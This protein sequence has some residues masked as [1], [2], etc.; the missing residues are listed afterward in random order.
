MTATIPVSAT[1]HVLDDAAAVQFPN[2]TSYSKT[3][4]LLALGDVR[5]AMLDRGK[6]YEPSDDDYPVQ[7]GSERHF[8]LDADRV[9]WIRRGEDRDVVVH[10]NEVKGGFQNSTVPGVATGAGVPPAPE[11]VAPGDLLLFEVQPD[12]SLALILANELDALPEGGLVGQTLVRTADGYGWMDF[13]ADVDEVPDGGTPGFYLMKTAEGVAWREIVL[14]EGDYEQPATI[15]GTEIVDPSAPSSDYAQADILRYTEIKRSGSENILELRF[16]ADGHST[17]DIVVHVAPD[18]TLGESL[19][20]FQEQVRTRAGSAW[21]AFEAGIRNGRIYISMGV[22]SSES[23]TVVSNPYDRFGLTPDVT[24]QPVTVAPSLKSVQDALARKVEFSH[25]GKPRGIATLGTDGKVPAR[26]LPAPTPP[27]DDTEV[28]ANIAALDGRVT[29]LEEAGPSG[30]ETRLT[31]AEEEL[32][33]APSSPMSVTSSVPYEPTTEEL[34]PALIATIAGAPAGVSA[35][36]PAN[37]SLEVVLQRL[38]DAFQSNGFTEWEAVVTVDGNISI[39]ADFETSEIEFDSYDDSWALLGFVEPYDIQDRVFGTGLGRVTSRL[40]DVEDRFSPAEYMIDA[41]DETVFGVHP[42]PE[43][44]LSDAAGLAGS[45]MLIDAFGWNEGDTFS[46]AFPSAEGELS[47]LVGANSSVDDLRNYIFD[48][49]QRNGDIIEKGTGQPIFFEFYIDN[50]GHLVVFTNTSFESVGSVTIPGFPESHSAPHPTNGL[51]DRFEGATLP[52]KESRLRLDAADFI[53]LELTPNDYVSFS[54][55]LD[56]S[57]QAVSITEQ[58][59][60]SALGKTSIDTLGELADVLN[61]LVYPIAEIS[62][63]YDGPDAAYME[64]MRPFGTEGPNVFPIHLDN[65]DVSAANDLGLGY[66]MVL[67]EGRDYHDV[68]DRFD[69][70]EKAIGAIEEQLEGTI[71]PGTPGTSAVLEGGLF[72]VA[73][74]TLG[75]VVFDISFDFGARATITLNQ[76]DPAFADPAAAIIDEVVAAIATQ[77]ANAGLTG[78]VGTDAS[79]TKIAF[80]SLT[81]GV[82]S[83]VEITNLIDPSGDTGLANGVTYGQDGTPEMSLKNRL[84]KLEYEIAT[85]LAAQ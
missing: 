8:H 1:S 13:P 73:D 82:N 77:L 80:T 2:T 30:L 55:H 45:S 49:V 79:G 27:Y 74:I 66:Y 64:F 20:G 51:W 53:P 48:T 62:T 46:L 7:A 71:T 28:V 40:N 37:S 26:Q 38:N 35:Y 21:A 83:A 70:N 43:R 3:V 17:L 14:P 33:G 54:L 6:A 65:F 15:H 42:Q 75:D 11:G 68:A 81:T 29:T 24:A 18:V 58:A 32:E 41:L 31:E 16:D 59:V 76:S 61:G 47:F 57:T 23:L 50:E 72:G 60:S 44:F 10:V 36:I 78:A 52:A 56:G 5:V 85:L 67:V 19:A 9:L 25:L 4:R 39:V 63:S 69:A 84:A 34:F 12:N 22:G